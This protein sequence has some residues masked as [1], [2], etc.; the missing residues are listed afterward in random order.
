MIVKSGDDMTYNEINKYIENGSGEYELYVKDK[1]SSTNDEIKPLSDPG[2]T[3]ILVS[4]SQSGGRGRL[5]RVFSSPKGGL[6]ISFCRKIQGDIED[7]FTFMPL[8]ALCVCNMLEAVCGIKCGI[9]WP[10]DVLYGGKKI[11]GILSE[12]FSS[13]N[14]NYLILGIGVNLNSRI[15]ENQPGAVSVFEAAGEET[16]LGRAAGVLINEVMAVLN[17]ISK[18]KFLRD[19]KVRCVNLGKEVAVLYNGERIQGIAEDISENGAL[20]IR[21]EDGSKISI[22]SGE[23]TMVKE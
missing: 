4:L 8:S 15:S 19:Y 3:V 6:Y 18:E 12:M 16:D 17:S 5:G 9:K 13:G 7:I 10:N 21:K 2:R 1:V 14:E 23:A 20:I 11:C 22:F